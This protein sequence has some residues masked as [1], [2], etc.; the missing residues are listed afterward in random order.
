VGFHILGSLEVLK[1]G[2]SVQVR[3]T[4]QTLEAEIRVVNLEEIHPPALGA[5]LSLGR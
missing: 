1:D 4:L 5:P 2:A 3:G